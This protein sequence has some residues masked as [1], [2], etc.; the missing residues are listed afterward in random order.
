VYAL[1]ACRTTVRQPG[2]ADFALLRGEGSQSG[3]VV[4]FFDVPSDPGNRLPRD[5]RFSADC[6]ITFTYEPVLAA[7]LTT[8]DDGHG[9]ITS[10]V[11]EDWYQVDDCP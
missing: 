2:A 6:C 8:S 9:D 5:S 7:T 1:W 10:R 11:N 4:N 3:P